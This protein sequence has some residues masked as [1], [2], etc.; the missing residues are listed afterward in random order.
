MELIQ[1]HSICTLLIENSH[2]YYQFY[3][4][5]TRTCSAQVIL[6]RGA[7]YVGEQIAFSCL[8]C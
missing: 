3:S 2:K 4:L 6:A 5:A 7:E 8:G 1:E